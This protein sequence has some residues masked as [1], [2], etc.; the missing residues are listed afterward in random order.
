M[1]FKITVGQETQDH[2]DEDWIIIQLTQK[3][4]I[5]EYI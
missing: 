5:S 1:L 2:D 3:Q 4:L